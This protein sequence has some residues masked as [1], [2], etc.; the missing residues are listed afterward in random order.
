MLELGQLRLLD[1]DTKLIIPVDT[2]VRFICTSADV[3]HCFSV[4]SLGVKIDCNPG[5]LNQVSV[6]AEREGVFYGTCA[7]L[8][9][10]SHSAMPISVEVVS[11]PK[12]LE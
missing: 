7:E 8:C 3:I 6:L 5:R 12:F 9:G 10:V 4:P 11:L 1:C 2:H